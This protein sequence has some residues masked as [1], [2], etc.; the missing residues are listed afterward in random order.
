MDLPN[1]L[2]V[3]EWETE[4]ARGIVNV[5]SSKVRS[6]IKQCDEQAAT[7]A[8]S[9]RMSSAREFFQ[10][11]E[12]SDIEGDFQ[13]ISISRGQSFSCLDVGDATVIERP[14]TAL[15]PITTLHPGGAAAPN[16][17]VDGFWQ[18]HRRADVR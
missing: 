6:D 1:S 5:Y 16:D 10:N 4:L 17:L 7:A 14:G 18:C 12:A 3:N 9:Y 8:S 2:P 15:A 13:R 11:D